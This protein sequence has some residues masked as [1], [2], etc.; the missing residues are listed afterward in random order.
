VVSLFHRDLG[1]TG[2]PP[3]VLLHGMLGSSRNWQTA[4]RDLT[5]KFH[6]LALDL[7][8]H[9]ASPHAPT[10][11]YDEMMADVIGWMDARGLRRISLLGHSMGG[12][13][14]MLLACRHPERIARLIVVDIAPKKYFWTGHRQSFAAM[15]ELNLADLHSRAEA[16]L[17]FEA[18]VPNWGTRKFLT[19]NLERTAEGKWFWQINL[20]VL[21]AALPVLESNP[22]RDADCFDGP[23]LFIAGGK[24]NYIESED[25]ATIRTHFPAAR[26]ETVADAGHNPHMETRAEFVRAVLGG[27]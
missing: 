23:V 6:V 3:L 24:S 16:E 21:T 8:N 22:L 20:P 19:T 25:Y 1:G 17:R 15:N 10:M 5:E 11:S 26:I 14:A 18:R 12:K 2:H 7:R 4:G 9:G 27:G 13:V